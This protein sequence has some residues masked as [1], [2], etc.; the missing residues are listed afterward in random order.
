MENV[1]KTIFLATS[2]SGHVDSATGVVRDEF[3]VRLEAVLAALRSAGFEVYC[4]IE[5]EGWRI[6]SKAPGVSMAHNFAQ[7]EA[8]DIFLALVDA[9]G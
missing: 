2:F 7:I 6:A 3:R 4:A 5:A 1:N 9:A 8:H